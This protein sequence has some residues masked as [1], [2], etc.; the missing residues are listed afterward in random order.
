MR[1][2]SCSVSAGGSGLVRTYHVSGQF[3]PNERFLFQRLTEINRAYRRAAS[4]GIS[5][6]S[7]HWV[8]AGY[9]RTADRNTVRRR[10]ILRKRPRFDCY[11]GPMR[12]NRPSDGKLAL[13][14]TER[15]QL[16]RWS[17][18]AKARHTLTL[19]SRIMSTCAVGLS[20]NRVTVQAQVTPGYRC[21]RARVRPATTVSSPSSGARR[22]RRRSLLPRAVPSAPENGQLS[23]DLA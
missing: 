10:T 17:W 9:T 23:F 18:W 15:I 16:V 13:A 12:S 21:P 19:R 4:A 6:S 1:S 22:P 14:D 11:G 5:S 20:D 8:A 3:R 2:A 7:Q